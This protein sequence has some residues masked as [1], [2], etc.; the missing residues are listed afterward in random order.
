MNQE[1]F[2][3]MHFDVKNLY[4]EEVIT[5]QKIGT[6]RVMTPI[7]LNGEIDEAR[8]VQYVGQTQ[9]LTPGGALPLTFELPNG[10]LEQAIAGFAEGA[11]T[12]MERTMEEIREMRRQQASQ[13]VMPG[14][15]PMGNN[16]I[17]M[18]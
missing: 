11:K 17:Q 15:S 18:P 14:D 2:P 12:A 1:S 9:V 7:S 3:E 6:I 13:I 10:S 4:R 16:K 8:E 5:D